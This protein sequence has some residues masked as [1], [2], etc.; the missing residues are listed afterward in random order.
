MDPERKK[1]VQAVAAVSVG[2]DA[3]Y[4][5]FAGRSSTLGLIPSI[6]LYLFW[7]VVM[8]LMTAYAR[9]VWQTQKQVQPIDSVKIKLL[10]TLI[11]CTLVPPLVYL[12]NRSAESVSL[13]NLTSKLT[14]YGA[15]L[16]HIGIT[17]AVYFGIETHGKEW[18]A[19]VAKWIAV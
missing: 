19:G 5:L 15:L 9:L 16:A 8:T 4:Y 12:T 1:L 18:M 3:I 10:S 14:S 13:G 17:V 2:F 11:V 7:L 6:A